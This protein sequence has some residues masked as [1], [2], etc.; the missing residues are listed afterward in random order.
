[1]AIEILIQNIEVLQSIMIAV[2]TGGPRIQDANNEYRAKYQE[3]EDLLVLEHIENPNPYSDLWKWY[4]R[5]SSGDLPTYQS[6]REYVINMYE[7]LLKKLR[8][9]QAGKASKLDAQPTGWARVDRGVDKV[10]G[11]LENAKNEED[12]QGV[13]LFCR[14]ALISAAQEVYNP[15]KHKTLDSISPSDTDANRMLEAYIAVELGGKSNEAARRVVKSA[16]TLANELQHRRIATFKEA[17]LCAEATFTV[18]NLISIVS[19]H[20]HP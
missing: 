9:I 10:K 17:A 12:F 14:E 11:Q 2:A 7:V 20:L 13:G 18:I 4:G 8:A 5:W 16:L 1:M 3:V 19:G 15:E 6:R